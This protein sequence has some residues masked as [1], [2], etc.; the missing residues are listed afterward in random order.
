MTT[1]TRNVIRTV[2]ASGVGN[3]LEW[4][5][6]A[7]F[8]IFAKQIGENFFAAEDQFTAS[9]AAF[10]VFGGA[11]IARPIGGVVLSHFADRYGRL[12]ALR[13]TIIGMALPTVVVAF[14]LPVFAWMRCG[15][16]WHCLSLFFGN[17][18]GVMAKPAV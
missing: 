7:L 2:V 16:F 10:S 13:A 1:D 9:M 6:F 12:V 18:Y 8:G 17:W 4:Y 14:L 11:F 5:D 15:L 3:L